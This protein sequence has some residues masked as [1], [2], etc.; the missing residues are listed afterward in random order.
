MPFFPAEDEKLRASSLIR[1]RGGNGPNTLEVLQHLI[2]GQGVGLRLSLCSVLPSATSLAAEE[3]SHSLGPDVDLSCC[4][5]RQE[6]TEAASSYIIRSLET[7][8]RTI[9]NY[10]DLP[11]MEVEE[12][13]AVVE[14]F[15]EEACWFH[16]EVSF[17]LTS[18]TW[19]SRDTGVIL[20]RLLAGKN[21]RHNAPVHTVSKSISSYRQN[22]CRGR[23]TWPDRLVETC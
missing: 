17:Q 7:G 8:S 12:F 21:P 6:H 23:E 18:L 5:Y 16:F 11:E 14:R 13:S 3:V 2:K 22:Q 15:R 1:R 19:C 20:T 4:I 10:N 9:V